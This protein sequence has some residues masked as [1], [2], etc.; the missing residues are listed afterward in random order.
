M[1]TV[2]ENEV[3]F[4]I[5]LRFPLNF[6]HTIEKPKKGSSAVKYRI[7]EKK[8]NLNSE[9]EVCVLLPDI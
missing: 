3:M 1:L 7:T 6:D 9:G 4:D 2:V 5:A 8:I